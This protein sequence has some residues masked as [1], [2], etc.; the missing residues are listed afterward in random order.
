VNYCFETWRSRNHDVSLCG[1][2]R[3]WRT[4]TASAWSIDDAPSVLSRLRPSFL[5]RSLAV[6]R[7]PAG[8]NISV[9]RLRGPAC[10][11]KVFASNAVAHRADRVFLSSR[12]SGGVRPAPAA[13]LMRSR[14]SSF[15]SRFFFNLLNTVVC[16]SSVSSKRAPMS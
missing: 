10:A 5:P 13:S 8:R 3:R 12:P 11:L 9:P 4:N 1:R 16:R 2:P 14:I 7:K 15:E 6:P